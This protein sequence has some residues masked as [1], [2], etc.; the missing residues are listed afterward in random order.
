MTPKI[1]VIDDESGIRDILGQLLRYHGY[2]VVTSA[3]AEEG[4]KALSESFFNIIVLDI[5]LP[6][7][8]GTMLLDKVEQLAPGAKVV[9]ITGHPSVETAIRALR[10]HSYDY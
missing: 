9:L 4:L 2:E 1:L 6:D 3:N 7:T 10:K 5:Q 8:P